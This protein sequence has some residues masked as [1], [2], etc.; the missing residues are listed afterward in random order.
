MVKF[1]RREVA[2]AQVHVAFFLAQNGAL[3]AWF[4]R[5]DIFFLKGGFDW[6]F[7]SASHER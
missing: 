3:E 2:K 6:V 1:H 7:F 4:W 5:M